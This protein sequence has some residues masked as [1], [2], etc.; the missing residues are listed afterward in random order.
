LNAAWGTSLIVIP[1]VEISTQADAP[2]EIHI[3]GYYVDYQY[4]PLQERL[5]ALRR[6]R[7]DRAHRVIELLAENGCTV[8]WQRVS[9]LAGK[10]SIGRPHIAQAMVEANCV[11]SVDAAFRLY[12]GRGCPAYVPRAKLLPEEAIQLVLDAHGIPILAHP[13]RVIEHIP[14]LVQA[15]LQGLEAYYGEYL[16]A[17]TEFLLSLAQK[18]DLLI[19]GGT[20]YHGAGLTSAPAPGSTYVPLAIIEDLCARADR[21]TRN[22]APAR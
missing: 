13:S 11:D 5:R 14:R 10:G 9:A 2:H 12:L 1:G 16:E 15:G 3:L 21:T 7:A 19:T 6:S 4:A 22:H 8:S 20:D 17:E 18:H